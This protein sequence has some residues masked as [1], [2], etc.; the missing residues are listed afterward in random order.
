MT[1]LTLD[2]ASEA[3]TTR[4]GRALSSVL[5]TGDC[6]LLDGPI[7]AGK[8]HLARAFIRAR[9]GEGEDV[10]SPTF[11]LVQTYPGEPEIWHADL[12]RL[13]HPDEVVELGLEDAFTS[14][15]CLIEWPDRLGDILPANPIRVSLKPAGEGRTATLTYENRPDLAAVLQQDMQRQRRADATLEFLAQTGWDKSNP[16]CPRRRCLDP[17]L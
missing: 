17:P 14:A 6:V 2:L 1:T 10:P 16:N 5:Q 7:G 9:L 8:T 3:D 12:Y 11:T 15:I 4:L 13:T